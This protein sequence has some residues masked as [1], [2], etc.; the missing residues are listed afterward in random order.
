MDSGRVCEVVAALRRA[1]AELARTSIDALTPRE[2]L[3][4]L[5]ELEVPQT[6]QIY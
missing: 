2:L 6:C 1:H 5:S 3:S 4:M